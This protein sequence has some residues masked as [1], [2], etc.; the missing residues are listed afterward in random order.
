MN[1]ITRWFFLFVMV[2]GP[3]LCVLGILLMSS[4]DNWQNRIADKKIKEFDAK[5]KRERELANQWRT[6]NL[7][8][9]EKM[10]RESGWYDGE[11]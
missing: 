1:D 8:A 4:W 11:R 3:A 5:R 10:R 2:I 9:Q 7:D 6:N